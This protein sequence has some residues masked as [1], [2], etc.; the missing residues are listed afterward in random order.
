MYPRGLNPGAG[1]VITGASPPSKSPPNDPIE[2][3]L[4]LRSCVGRKGTDGEVGNGK[5]RSESEGLRCRNLERRFAVKDLE[6][7]IMTCRSKA[8]E[9]EA[10]PVGPLVKSG[11]CSREAEDALPGRMSRLERISAGF[12][13]GM[14]RN[15]A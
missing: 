7:T 6:Y 12:C 3:T 8:P 4:P 9:V 15:L 11:A 14:P 1:C 2:A 13:V 10:G 5:F